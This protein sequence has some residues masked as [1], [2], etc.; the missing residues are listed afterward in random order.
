MVVL[1]RELTISGV[2][3]LLPSPQLVFEL[4]IPVLLDDNHSQVRMTRNKQKNPSKRRSG[5]LV[6][7]IRKSLPIARR[8][9]HRS[10]ISG[11]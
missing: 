1:D 8:S 9:S 10:A 2:A 6:F 4:D 7:G 11:L 3:H 5:R